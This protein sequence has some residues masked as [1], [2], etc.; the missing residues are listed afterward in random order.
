[1]NLSE[2]NGME[3]DCMQID[4]RTTKQSLEMQMTNNIDLQGTVIQGMST[5]SSGTESVFNTLLQ[6]MLTSSG[7]VDETTSDVTVFN[8]G[9]AAYIDGTLWQLLF[10]AT[11]LESAIDTITQ[12]QSNGSVATGYDDLISQA[13]RTYGVAESLI[14]A[15]IDTESSFNAQAVSSAGAKGL[16]QL[17]D[18][19]AQGLGVSNSFDPAQNIDGGTRYL[20]YQLTRFQGAEKLALAAYNAGP[21]TLKRLGITNEKELMDKLHLLPVE[22]QKYISKVD[23]ARAKYA[24]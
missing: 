8:S 21:G 20:S 1:M 22:T 7:L 16:M 18:G 12:P 3:F 6:D 23:Q 15:V 2:M 10:P 13:S 4:P 19:T 11:S 17:M 5:S 9:T 24:V 14:K